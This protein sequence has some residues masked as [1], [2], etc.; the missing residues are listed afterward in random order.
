M[1]ANL[2]AR[3]I[4]QRLVVFQGDRGARDDADAEVFLASALEQLRTACVAEC[5]ADRAPGAG[6]GSKDIDEV[7]LLLRQKHRGVDEHTDLL[8]GGL[9]Q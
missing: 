1:G 3:T 8:V 6:F 7:D 2:D 5:D 4:A 9:K